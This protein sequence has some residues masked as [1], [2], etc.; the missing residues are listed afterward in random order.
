M[1][2]TI[3]LSSSQGGNRNAVGAVAKG[4][5][6]SD[7]GA[8]DGAP[9]PTKLG[10]ATLAM[11]GGVGTMMQDLG[12]LAKA[13]RLS[14][15]AI[16]ELQQNFFNKLSE[17]AGS[18]PEA[19]LGMRAAAGF[20]DHP[21]QLGVTKVNIAVDNS[22]GRAAVEIRGDVTVGSRR[23]FVAQTAPQT[24]FTS[25]PDSQPFV[26][27]T[28]GQTVDLQSAPNGMYFD[29][30]GSSGREFTNYLNEKSNDSG[31]DGG[32]GTQG[33]N[34]GLGREAA[35]G[36]RRDDAEKTTRDASGTP[37]DPLAGRSQGKGKGQTQGYRGVKA[38]NDETVGSSVLSRQADSLGRGVADDKDGGFQ[39]MIVMR[40]GSGISPLAQ[41]GVTRVQFD[42][43]TDINL[44]PPVNA[45]SPVPQAVQ[46]ERTDGPVVKTSEVDF[47]A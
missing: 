25:Y 36:T 18:P 28:Q 5:S 29:I 41:A 20:V 24:D 38:G 27:D 9:D 19:S 40:S 6:G 39:S 31:R 47:T 13:F 23:Q 37:I 32:D 1:S 7:S 45:T 17:K 26:V 12:R 43:V 10:A 42:M 30:R 15:G 34:A 16:S 22:T 4:D 8:V 3:A 11:A 46:D 33:G 2:D 44:R 35:T 21:V 14:A